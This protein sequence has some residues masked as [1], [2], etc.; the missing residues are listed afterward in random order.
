M[1]AEGAFATV[2]AEVPAGVVIVV[3]VAETA[4]VVAAEVVVLI[5]EAVGVVVLVAAVV[6]L[7]AGVQYLH[8]AASSG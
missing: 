5:A 4:E 7:V 6:I 2:V 8:L 3:L 1:V